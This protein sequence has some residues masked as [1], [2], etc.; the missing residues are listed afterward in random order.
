ML[1]QLL[2]LLRWALAYAVLDVYRTVRK[3]MGRPNLTRP[4][5]EGMNGLEVTRACLEACLEFRRVGE[6]RHATVL[7]AGFRHFRE[8]WARDFGFACYGLLAEGRDQVVEDGLRLFFRHQKPNGQLPLK[9]HSTRLLERY[10]HSVLGRVQPDETDLIPRYLTAHGTR[11]LDSV[12]LLVIAWGEYLRKT[13]QLGELAHQAHKALEWVERMRDGR[14]LIQQ[15]PYA[16]WADTIGR[17]G[18][19]LYTNV[20]WW[21]ARTM[22]DDGQAEEIGRNLL[23]YFY[24][25]GYLHNTPSSPVFTSPAN[26][27]AVAW[28]LTN[29]EQSRAIL[30]YADRCGISRVVPARVTDRPYPFYQVSPLMWLAGISHYHTSCSW[31]WIGGWHAVACQRAGRSERAQEILHKMLEVVERDRTVFE[32]HAP[33][34]KPLARKLYHSEEPLSW[35]AAMI[36]YAHSVVSHG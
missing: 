6:N 21:K 30:D 28:G 34:G 3:V 22:L 18:A 36:L 29:E 24:K 7:C 14:G 8:P 20:L 17:R 31:M 12:L 10:L 26:F 2:R 35:N 32:V 5:T 9:L 1:V 25:D 27:M 19:V 16:D 13:G 23:G 11:S 33:D 15:G 4:A